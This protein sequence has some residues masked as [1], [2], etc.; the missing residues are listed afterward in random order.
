VNKPDP[1]WALDDSWATLHT[2]R[3]LVL[4]FRR[5]EDHKPPHWPDP[6]RAQQ[7]HLDLG[8]KALDHARD[9]G[10]C[11]STGAFSMAKFSEAGR[12]KALRSMSRRRSGG[13]IENPVKRGDRVDWST[14]Y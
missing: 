10:F 3:G 9:I 2:D 1:R 14:T 5:V 6:T 13:P 7:S 11:A 4:A 8:V 12:K